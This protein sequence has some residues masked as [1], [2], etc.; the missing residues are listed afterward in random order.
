MN[1]YILLYTAHSI[2]KFELLHTLHIKVKLRV[3]LQ[4]NRSKLEKLQFRFCCHCL[5]ATHA[6]RRRMNEENIVWELNYPFPLSH[7]DVIYFN[8]AAFLSIHIR[9]RQPAWSQAWEEVNWQLLGSFNHNK[10]SEEFF[11]D[12]QRPIRRQPWGGFF[13]GHSNRHSDLHRHENQFLGLT[14]AWK[15]MPA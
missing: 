15:L 5:F 14:S 3:G 12:L 4:S 11:A 8:T 7:D 9:V 2:N 13:K 6:G 10:N 1:F